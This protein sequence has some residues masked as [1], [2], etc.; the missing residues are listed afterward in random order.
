VSHRARSLSDPVRTVIRVAP[1]PGNEIGLSNRTVGSAMSM[2]VREGRVRTTGVTSPPRPATST[3]RG[4]DCAARCGWE[5]TI[6]PAPAGNSVTALITALEQQPMDLTVDMSE[7]GFCGVRGFALLAAIARVTRT[8]GIGY[9]V[10]GLGRHL[11]RPT[12][13]LWADDA[14]PVPALPSPRR[15]IS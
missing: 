7:V 13:L 5:L 12:T 3:M 10:T 9:T 2:S 14:S 6:E 11:E 1:V 15:H 8:G 4:G